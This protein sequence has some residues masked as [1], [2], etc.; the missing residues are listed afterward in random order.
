M[1]KYYVVYT[2][3]DIGYYKTTYWVVCITE[4]E[5]VAK[6]LCQKFNYS[7]EVETV[8]KDRSTPDW[9]KSEEEHEDE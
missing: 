7:Y 2:G 9:V 8:G 6:D 5:E 1:K 3:K 4:D